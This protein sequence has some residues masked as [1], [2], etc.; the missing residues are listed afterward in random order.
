MMTIRMNSQS[1]ADCLQ[2]RIV[3]EKTLLDSAAVRFEDETVQVF[4]K[5]GKEDACKLHI[6]TL[7]AEHIMEY[8]EERM[9][10]RLIE[11]NYGYFSGP[12]KAEVLKG[13]SKMLNNMDKIFL[14]SLF[15]I[16]RRNILMRKLYD[17][18][19]SEEGAEL[20]L[21][22]FVNFRLQGYTKELEEV[23]SKAV[24]DFLVEKEY[25]EFIGLLRHF[26]DIQE[27][28]YDV[29]YVIPT[30][31]GRYNLFDKEEHVIEVEFDEFVKDLHEKD[32]VDY[33][34]FLVSSLITL[35]PRR[36]VI[37]G[38]MKNKE[39][40]RTIKAVFEKRVTVEEG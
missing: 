36:I 19:T 25:K 29:I 22:G 14:Q 27:P 28:K 6:A 30:E 23:V 20:I 24:D 40:V 33:N 18:F 4:P 31:N 3:K 2:E 9:V 10:K 39:I 16:R 12:D 26:V 35:A 13:C 11:Q 15:Q 34:D 8:H 21:Y 32:S 5:D 7:L 17:F 37:R 1:E 38:Q